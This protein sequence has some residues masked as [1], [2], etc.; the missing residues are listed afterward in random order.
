MQRG[1]AEPFR[2]VVE[3]GACLGVDQVGGSDIREGLG[4]RHGLGGELPRSCAV[5]I[6]GSERAAAV[7]KRKR[8]HGGDDS[9]VSGSRD[10]PAI[11]VP[12]R[13]ANE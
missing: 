9:V 13:P 2:P 1:L 10:G 7:V 3:V 6:Q 11:S 4:G 5:Q 8:E 12:P